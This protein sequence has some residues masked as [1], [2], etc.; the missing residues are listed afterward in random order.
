M[1]VTSSYLSGLDGA[2][3]DS[4]EVSRDTVTPPKLARDAP[5]PVRK[6][7]NQ[8]WKSPDTPVYFVPIQRFIK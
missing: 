3:A 5:V 7:T 8:V 6:K 2:V 4:D 1:K